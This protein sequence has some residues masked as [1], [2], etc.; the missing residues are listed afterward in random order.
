M[1]SEILVDTIF[2]RFTAPFD[3]PDRCVPFNLTDTCTSND[4]FIDD[5]KEKGFPDVLD[6]SPYWLSKKENEMQ[7]DII[8]LENDITK[9]SFFAQA[10]DEL[11]ANKKDT[12]KSFF[13]IY[14]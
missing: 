3:M 6:L 7:K 2:E 8:E 12:K 14:N 5:I 11:N 4:F 9:K 10:F 13:F 1:P